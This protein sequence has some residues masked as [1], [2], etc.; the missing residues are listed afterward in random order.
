MCSHIILSSAK[1]VLQKLI[2]HSLHTQQTLDDAGTNHWKA[3]L[4]AKRWN[5]N[6]MMTT[7]ILGHNSHDCEKSVSEY[8]GRWVHCQQHGYVVPLSKTL[9]QYCFSSPWWLMSTRWEHSHERCMFSAMSAPEK[10]APKNQRIIQPLLVDHIEL[11]GEPI[12]GELF[13][14]LFMDEGILNWCTTYHPGGLRGP[15]VDQLQ[16]PTPWT[17][18]A[19]PCSC[20]VWLMPVLLGPPWSVGPTRRQS[21]SQITTVHTHTNN[22]RAHTHR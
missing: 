5:S 12:H 15:V 9:Y 16:F 3:E 22:Y 21:S 2:I 19:C 7:I 8:R 1:V 20:A 18:T 6:D 11:D 10:I 14:T 17:S 4:S 13:V